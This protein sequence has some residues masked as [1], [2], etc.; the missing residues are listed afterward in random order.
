MGAA[1]ETDNIALPSPNCKKLISYE[2]LKK[3]DKPTDRW[4]LIENKVYDITN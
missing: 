4:L 2:E 3:H 1:K